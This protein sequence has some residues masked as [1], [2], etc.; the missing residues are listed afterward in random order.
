M[1]VLSQK[2]EDK[3]FLETGYR[4]DYIKKIVKGHQ[5]AMQKMF[6]DAIRQE[7][8]KRATASAAGA[9]PSSN[10]APKASNDDDEWEDVPASKEKV[11]EVVEMN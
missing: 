7:K 5:L 3:F 2:E 4:V 6:E 1:K 10:S 11:S 9:V 8:E